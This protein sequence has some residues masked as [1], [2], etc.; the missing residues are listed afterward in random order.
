MFA[1][2][3]WSRQVEVSAVDGSVPGELA[4]L[5][6]LCPSCP[7]WTA[8][9]KLERTSRGI[10]P[11]GTFIGHFLTNVDA[12]GLWCVVAFDDGVRLKVRPEAHM[13]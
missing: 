13:E 9:W 2:E 7:S 11:G 10:I 4:E 8:T 6:D 12:I 5:A 3:G 1:I